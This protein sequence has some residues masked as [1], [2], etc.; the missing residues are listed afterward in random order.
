VRLSELLHELTTLLVEHG[1][2]DVRVA[3]AG[4]LVRLDEVT[5]EELSLGRR[6]YVLYAAPDEHVR[7]VEVAAHLV[8]EVNGRGFARLPSLHDGR[9]VTVTA[10][11]SSSAEG[12]HVWLQLRNDV[13][14]VETSAHLHAVVAQHLIDQLSALLVGHYQHYEPTTE[15]RQ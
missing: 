11:E 4:R 9:G 14:R 5:Y 2:H 3:R 10:F 8:R 7:P 15:E 12:P 13:A 6:R 1:D